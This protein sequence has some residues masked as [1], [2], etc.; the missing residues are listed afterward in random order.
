MLFLLLSISMSLTHCMGQKMEKVQ[1]EKGDSTK[2]CYTAI[3][4]LQ[5]PWKGLVMIIPGFGETAEAVLEATDLPKKCAQNGLFTIIPTMQDGVFSFGVD[6]A[7]QASLTRIIQDVAAKNTEISEL[8]FYVGGFSIGGSAAIKYAESH[9]KSTAAVFAIDPPLDFERFY[10]VCKRGVRLAGTGAANPEQVYMLQ[11]IPEIMGGTP[12]T[13]IANYYKTSPYSFTDTTQSA[14][15]RL[16]NTPLRIYSEPDIQWWME[17]RG[18]DMSCLNIMDASGL[19]NELNRLGNR[20]AVLIAT[21]N[22]GFRRPNHVRHPH[23]W[24]IVDDAEMI[25]WLLQNQ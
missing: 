7:S 16:I 14:A 15:K 10:A 9:P 24:S 13:A 25:D 4:P 3:Y 11:R 5:K 17:H 8:P 23:S 6:S 1:L 22:K 20:K 2:N 12:E 21:E 19:I 18:S